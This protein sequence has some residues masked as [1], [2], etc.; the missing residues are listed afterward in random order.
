MNPADN[1]HAADLFRFLHRPAYLVKVICQMIIGL[2]VAVTLIAKV[3]MLVLTD[4]QCTPD[5]NTLGNSIRC[6]NTLAIMAYALALYAGFE[7]AFRMFREGVQGAIDPLIIG[8][9]SVFLLLISMLN[10]ES[11]NWQIAMLLTSLT[12][13]IAALL[14][15]RERFG[16]TNNNANRSEQK[17]NLPEGQTQ[18]QGRRNMPWEGQSDTNR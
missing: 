2:G 18:Q 12:L 14:F 7:L 6:G 3:Y 15:C 1:S 17:A 10:L 16:N 5:M 11:A 9:C 13:T 4:Y 8:V